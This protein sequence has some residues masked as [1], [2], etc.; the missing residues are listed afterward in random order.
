MNSDF[1][2]NLKIFLNKIGYL[3]EILPTYSMQIQNTYWKFFESDTYIL[4][5]FRYSPYII[6][7]KE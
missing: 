2:V 4:R 5:H 3:V 6:F 1:F 7:S